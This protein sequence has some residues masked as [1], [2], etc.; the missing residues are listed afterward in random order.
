LL[1]LDSRKF[2]P[3]IKLSVV[4]DGFYG[5]YRHYFFKSIVKRVEFCD[6]LTQK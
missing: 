3:Y 2:T 6:N 5:F 1:G 4:Q